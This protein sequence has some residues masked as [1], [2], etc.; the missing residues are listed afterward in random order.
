MS[1]YY[2]HGFE[3]YSGIIGRSMQLMFKILSEGIK[4]RN[5]VSNRYDDKYNHVCLYKKNDEYDYDEKDAIYKSARGG[6]IDKCFVIVINPDIDA[7][8]VP[9]G[10]D[11]DLV[12]EWRCDHNI[13]PSEFVGIALPLSEIETYLIENDEYDKED[14][15]ILK[16]YY[17][18]VLDLAKILGLTVYD[19]EQKDFTDIIDFELSK[20]KIE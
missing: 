12:D 16:E 13:P 5:Q 7:Y 17:P 4:V 1:G 3:P 11:T 8:K 6:W 19:S 14:R 15:E 2:Y 20:N 18:K 10:V 9:V